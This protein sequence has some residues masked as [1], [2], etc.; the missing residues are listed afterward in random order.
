MF[1]E[2]LHLLEKLKIFR[3]L[4]KD[5]IEKYLQNSEYTIKKLRTQEQIDP[6]KH[7]MK[8]VIPIA[9]CVATYQNNNGQT[10]YI[11]SFAPGENE[12]VVVH[13][14]IEQSSV[15]IVAKQPSVVLLLSYDSFTKPNYNIL[16]I[17]NQ[18]QGNIIDMVFITS[19]NVLER[20]IINSVPSAREK[21]MNFINYLIEEQGNNP[22]RVHMTRNM[23]ADYL[24]IDTSTLMR[25][26]KKLKAEGIIDYNR[27]YIYKKG[28][29]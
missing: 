13:P 29:D 16:P 9:G 3:G 26:L 20:D 4:N 5:Q 8:T 21:I 2:Y 7:G 12:M 15:V 28:Q 17:Q 27:K 19:Q 24:K 25:E 23:L 18:V 22:I 10:S 14:K 1:Y 6:A 11:A